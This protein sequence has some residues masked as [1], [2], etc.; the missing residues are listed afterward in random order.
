MADLDVYGLCLDKFGDVFMELHLGYFWNVGA[1][2]K[3]R[4]KL[5][6]DIK[7]DVPLKS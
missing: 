4:E 2:S 6:S 7:T 1:S 3:A 5:S